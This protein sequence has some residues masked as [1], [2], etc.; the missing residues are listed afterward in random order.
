MMSCFN[1][2]DEIRN[3]NA[4]KKPCAGHSCVVVTF[5][6]L[7]R[8]FARNTC[9]VRSCVFLRTTRELGCGW[10]HCRA[11]S[12]LLSMPEFSRR[13]VCCLSEG[14]LLAQQ[15][16]CSLLR[17]RGSNA[18]GTVAPWRPIVVTTVR[19]VL[20]FDFRCPL[21]QHLLSCSVAGDSI[22]VFAVCSLPS[23][24]RTTTL[25]A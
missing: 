11:Q 7:I 25:K 4:E 9:E 16:R 8:H 17:G 6:F 3:S 10:P 13:S 18:R 20:K 14:T 12:A 15:S 1:F 2:L 23:S 22:L 19:T 5:G 24:L 21:W